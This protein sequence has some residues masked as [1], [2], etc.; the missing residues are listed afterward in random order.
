VQH[1]LDVTDAGSPVPQAQDAVVTTPPLRDGS[2]QQRSPRVR[3]DLA[4]GEQMVP[5]LVDP[6]GVAR[7]ATKDAV[8]WD[9]QQMLQ[10]PDERS[11]VTDP[12]HAMRHPRSAGRRRRCRGS[13]HRCDSTGAGEGAQRPKERVLHAV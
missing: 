12:Q 9:V 13:E 4:V 2:A 1:P 10:P 3:A 11:L 7:V 8:G 5:S 6:H